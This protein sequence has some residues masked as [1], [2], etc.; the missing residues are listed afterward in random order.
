[1]L[2]VDSAKRDA[3]KTARAKRV[4][5]P[6]QERVAFSKVICSHISDLT[7]FVSARVITGFL[8][9][10]SEVNLSALLLSEPMKPKVLGIPRTENDGMTFDAVDLHDASALAVGEFGIAVTRA[11]ALIYPAD[12][13]LV[14]VP[15]LAF[16]REGNRL[17]AGRAFYDRWLPQATKAYR[18]GVAFSD[19]ECEAVPVDEH[20]QRLDA[21]VTE[22]GVRRFKRN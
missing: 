14:L 12:V 15:L 8:A 19:Q 16:D 21:I 4:A 20:D 6:L 22:L 17:G 13:D 3:R 7:E 18:L 5:I 11:R 1:M 9:I 10:Q 2:P